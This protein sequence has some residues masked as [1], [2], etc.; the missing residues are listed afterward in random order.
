M[1]INDICKVIGWQF[2]STLIEHLIIKN[3]TLDTNLTTDKVVY[4]N[5]L[6]RLN[7]K[8]DNI[9][10]AICNKLIHLLARHTQRVTHLHAGVGI[11]LEVL[12]LSTLCLKF[13]WCVE[14]YICLAICKEFLY[15]CLVDVAALALTVWAVISAEAYSFVEFYA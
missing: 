10:L 8:A 6:A 4:E 7:L 15:V 11:I 14:C 13:F 2:V 3:I 12:Y 9:L 1:V 5:L